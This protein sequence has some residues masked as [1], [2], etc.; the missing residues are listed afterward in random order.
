MGASQLA[1]LTGDALAKYELSRQALGVIG[2]GFWAAIE[3]GI[4][5]G[6]YAVSTTGV[7]PE[8]LVAFLMAAASEKGW[9][10]A[11]LSVTDGAKLKITSPWRIDSRWV[12]MSATKVSPVAGDWELVELDDIKDAEE[13]AD[14]AL[15]LNPLFEGNPGY[16]RNRF[17]VGARDEQGHLIA[18]GTCRETAAGVGHLAG[19]VVRPDKRNK[20][21]G[22]AI[23]SSLSRRVLA[24][25]SIVTLSAYADNQ[26]ALH[27]YKKLGFQL[28]HVFQAWGTQDRRPGL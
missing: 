24:Q 14:F 1:R 6:G 22:A 26:T 2:D 7:F 17:W 15:T 20:G 28:D 12:W 10:L 3:P 19:L 16:G 11:W 18:C 27:L 4:V 25:E 8:D 21:L 23:V 13:I 9:R 5:T